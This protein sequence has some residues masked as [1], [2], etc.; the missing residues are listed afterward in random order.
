MLFRISIFILF[1]LNLYGS[2]FISI[3]RNLLNT[4]KYMLWINLQKKSVLCTLNSMITKHTLKVNADFY[5]T[6]ANSTAS[7]T[8]PTMYNIKAFL[9]ISLWFTRSTISPKNKEITIPRDKFTVAIYFLSIIFWLIF[10]KLTI[11]NEN[12]DTKIPIKVKILA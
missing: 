8:I 1:I 2:V 10:V 3:P 4:S 6:K 11:I 7:N 5:I 9:F 12:T